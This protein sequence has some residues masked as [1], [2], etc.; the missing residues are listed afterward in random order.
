MF[1][2]AGLDGLP[3]NGT[4]GIG[5]AGPNQVLADAMGIVVSVLVRIYQIFW[6]LIHP[7][8]LHVFLSQYST[9]H[10]EPMAR[11]T[12]E[13][14]K[15]GKGE[16]NYTVNEEFLDTFWKYGAERAKDY[17]T[18]FT[19]GMRGDGDLPLPGASIERLEKIM[20]DQR[21]IISAA[22]GGIAAEKV[23]QV[24]ALYKEV[25][26]YYDTDG[27]TVPDDVT[28]L[29]SDDNWG[30]IRRVG[31]ANETSRSGGAAQYYHLGKKTET[32]IAQS[33][34]SD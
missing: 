2:V 27:M 7:F 19:V 3:N 1:A 24:F 28:L 12:P 31:L 29:W 17:E 34:H 6:T 5:A 30:N 16:W 21:S 10:Q 26:G 22:H 15:Y 11:N 18:L 20:T 25:Q 33:K 8:F 14:S 9:S 13:W 4:N 32:Y 23:P